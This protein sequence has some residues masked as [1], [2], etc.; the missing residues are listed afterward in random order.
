MATYNQGYK[1]NPPR[2][3]K[4]RYALIERIVDFSKTP[5]TA[6]TD[7]GRLQGKGSEVTTAWAVN[8]IL[9]AIQIRAGQTVL[10]VQVEII[11]NSPDSGD[12]IQIGYGSAPAKWGD[13][14]L[15]KKASQETSTGYVN[16][17]AFH[18]SGWVY[19]SN[20][21]TIDIKIR[22][23]ALVGKIRIVVH[24]LEDDR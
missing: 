6:G 18:Q 10:G 11:K 2:R 17:D 9:Q 20:A 14:S 4:Q 15:Y 7:D 23:A 13:Y 1:W 8:D 21:D 3:K 12:R 5:V 24:I 16:E 19:F 22:K